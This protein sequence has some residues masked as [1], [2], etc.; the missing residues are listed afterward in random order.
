MASATYCLGALEGRESSKTQPHHRQPPAPAS[1]H[2]EGTG[3]LL[4]WNRFGEPKAD[5]GSRSRQ[6]GNKEVSRSA[7]DCNH[8][9]QPGA[10]SRARVKPTFLA[11]GQHFQAS[12]HSATAACRRR[13]NQKLVNCLPG[14]LFQFQGPLRV[15]NF[16]E[17]LSPQVQC[18]ITSWT[19]RTP[20]LKVVCSNEGAWTLSYS[21][22]PFSPVKLPWC[23]D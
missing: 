1:C 16:K 14:L 22:P 7:G 19:P 5:R 4:F 6:E 18:Y 15:L 8:I 2:G 10:G 12:F 13:P 20:L 23:L 3:S 21:P 11:E 17:T 9:P